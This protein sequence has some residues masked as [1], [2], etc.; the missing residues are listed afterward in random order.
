MKLKP[1]QSI[2]DYHPEMPGEPPSNWQED[3]AGMRVA[4]I[5]DDPD[6][7]PALL[8]LIAKRTADAR[9][10]ETAEAFMQCFSPE[11][12]DV[13]VADIRLSEAMSGINLLQ[14]I[15]EKHPDYP[16]ILLTGFDSLADAIQAVRLGAQ[17][18]ILKPLD[19]LDSL[20]LPIRRAVQNHRLILRNK[21]LE[22]ALRE[23]EARLRTVLENSRD[24]V[25]QISLPDGVIEYVSP[26]A[27]ALLGLDGGTLVGRSAESC[28]ERVHADD[29]DSVVRHVTAMITAV[30]AAEPSLP[31]ECRV[32]NGEGGYR[33]LS[34]CHAP[35]R[36]GD[37]GLVIGLV[38]NARDVTLLKEQ[39]ANER[40][41]KERMARV[42]RLESLSVLAG[43]IAHDLN[44]ILCSV[45]LLPR[46]VQQKLR[47][48]KVLD[49]NPDLHDDLT[50][51]ADSAQRAGDVV[52]DLLTLSRSGRR[53]AEPTDVNKVVRLYLR[54]ALFRSLME[55]NK[56]VH[57]EERLAVELPAVSGVEGDFEHI[58][59]NLVI[60]ACDAMPVG[61]SIAIVTEQVHLEAALNGFEIIPAGHYVVLRVRDTG[62]GIS[63]E[64]L[65]RIFDPFF[66]TKRL[67]RQ[68]GSGL[69]LAVVH[70]VV[71]THKGFVDVRTEKGRGT[72]FAFYFPA[73]AESSAFAELP[74]NLVVTGS[75]TI[76]LVDEDSQQ[77]HLG[78]RVLQSLGYEVTLA[79]SIDETLSCYLN[80]RS[81]V[82]TGSGAVDNPFDLVVLAAN[83]GSRIDCGVV[84]RKILERCPAQP[85][86]LVTDLS[87]DAMVE[88]LLTLGRGSNVGKPYSLEQLG[89]AV[90]SALNRERDVTSHSNG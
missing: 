61:G 79:G 24:L 21:A 31:L 65:D 32:S 85:Y 44:N 68:S 56:S 27:R 49:I 63:P 58:L 54:S 20:L 28:L 50:M 17:D 15:R 74:G 81:E 35:V 86:L 52:N 48:L 64:V 8:T 2:Y 78:R 36:A 90:R 76:L 11:T 46:L 88:P 5:E 30:H 10:F 9:L 87:Q 16:V 34:I 6:A 23:S 33:W 80:E 4:L 71:K 67:G 51:I 41:L 47:Q 43:G 45:S 60:N 39:E 70:A 18:Y 42:E 38:G 37:S 3:L 13:V 84:L 72:E 77:I 55:K 75:G 62:E 40:G 25:F 83:S 69:G 26:A 29:R 12:F 53:K 89:L 22:L 59:M 82:T 73:V 66:T 57:V 1:E 14:I 7:G 19:D